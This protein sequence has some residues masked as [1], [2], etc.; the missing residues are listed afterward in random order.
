M[1]LNVNEG[2][3]THRGLSTPIF[4]ILK[5]KELFKE[6]ILTLRFART[7]RKITLVSILPI[8]YQF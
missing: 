5:S 4:H 7:R 1:D 3:F 8:N 6:K 2:R